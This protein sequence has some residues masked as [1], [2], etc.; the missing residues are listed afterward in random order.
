MNSRTAFV[1]EEM[2]GSNPNMKGLL[3]EVPYKRDVRTTS[4]NQRYLN[5]EQKFHAA[6]ELMPHTAAF[7]KLKAGHVYRLPLKLINV[8]HLPQRFTLKEGASAALRAVYRPGMV[9]AGTSVPLELEVSSESAVEVRETLTILTE[10]EE[11]TLP[12]T[13]SVL[14]P[15]AYAEYVA[16]YGRGERRP[17]GQ[18]PPR[19]L[20]TTARPAD[21]EKVLAP[22]AG[23]N[24]GFTK[25]WA[26]PVKAPETRGEA[27][28][29]FGEPPSDED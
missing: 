2:A 19:L 17:P 20:A 7:G 18:A 3:V 23:D 5:T 14:E 11:I 16:A 6:F 8:S 13:A 24:L 1:S 28:D 12:V 29:F 21:L 22:R 15:D 27:P 10:R 25:G 26:K 4:V 9:A